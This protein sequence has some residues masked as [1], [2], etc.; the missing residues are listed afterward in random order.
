[1]SGTKTQGTRFQVAT[2]AGTP[3]NITGITAA[4]PPVVS[5]AAH[6]FANGAIVVLDA[7]VGM[8]ELNNRAFVVR[9]VASGTF[10][11]GG[12]DASGYT[13]WVS[14]GTATPQTM[15]DIGKVTSSSQFDGQAADIDTTHMRSTAMENQQG[16]PDFGSGS[17][18]VIID[19]TDT[20]QRRLRT[21]KSTQTAG[22]FAILGTDALID[23]FKAFVKSFPK[24]LEGNN[25]QRG[26]IAIKYE[27]EPSW[28]A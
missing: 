17:Y 19:N 24:N 8:V 15:A 14:G 6:G 13:A 21:L 20:A 10:E 7:I 25:V 11:L 26:D 23:A 22:V 3:K 18:N 28:A 27:T 9:N 2:A 16:L 4:N 1:M 12:I 5:S